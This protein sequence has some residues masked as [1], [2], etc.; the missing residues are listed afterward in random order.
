MLKINFESETVIFEIIFNRKWNKNLL[1]RGQA[2][3]RGR[4]DDSKLTYLFLPEYLRK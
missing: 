3:N 2:N 4:S 1:G